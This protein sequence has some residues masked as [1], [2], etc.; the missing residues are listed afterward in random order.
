MDTTCGRNRVGQEAEATGAY[1]E[2]LLW[3]P[4]EGKDK[5]E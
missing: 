3:F 5:A 4:W 1:V 2:P